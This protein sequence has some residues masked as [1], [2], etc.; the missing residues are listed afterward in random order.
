MT[1]LTRHIS[2]CAVALTSL[3]LACSLDETDTNGVAGAA[4][5][6]SGA[7][8]SGGAA[9]GSGGTASGAAGLG[10]GGSGGAATAGSSGTAT[11]GAGSA[12]RAGA[13]GNGG[14]SGGTAGGGAGGSTAGAGA[15]AG[16]ASGS[17]GVSAGGAGG[18]GGA[19]GGGT[20]GAGGS[21]GSTAGGGAGGTG[22]SA[23]ADPSEGCGK[24]GRPSGGVVTV[25]NDH[26]YTFP[27]S[28]DG[29]EAMPLFIGFHAAGNP[30][31]QIRTLTNGSEFEENYVR[32]FPKSAGNEWNYNGDLNKVLGMYD[33][34]M[35]NYCID[36]S[37]VFGAGHSS[38]AQM[39]VQILARAEPTEHINFKAVAPVA[40]SNYG[41]LSTAIPVMYIQGA[42]DSERDS[43]GADVVARFT[44]ANG[45]SM[46]TAPYAGVESCMSSGRAV[47]PGC[48]SY[49]GCTVPTVWCSHD[50]PQYSNTNH[51]W[52]CFATD[53]MY[54]FFEALP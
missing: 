39:I 22:G 14:A 11:G 12:G 27:T 46:N 15:S 41:A 28:Y 9:S 43:D 38:G 20:G 7:G 5:S 44:T 30:I 18:A 21:S 34:L 45:C 36:K 48:V 50:D 6:R 40:A 19:A 54:D 33:D 16:G 35:A 42:M 10:K 49:D 52:P 26:I 29:S 24:G 2:L 23:A 53:A 51:G 25:T 3:G 37:R 13:A 32:A 4:G 1:H 47:D 8:G 31:D 17:G